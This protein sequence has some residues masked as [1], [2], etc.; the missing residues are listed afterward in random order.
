MFLEES[1]CWSKKWVSIGFA[2]FPACSNTFAKTSSRLNSS[3]SPYITHY[4]TTNTFMSIL[5]FLSA[6]E[7]PV[8][9]NIPHH[10]RY[11]NSYTL[12]S[13]EFFF[14]RSRSKHH[15]YKFS[16]ALYPTLYRLSCLI[17]DI[18]DTNI[19]LFPLPFSLSFLPFSL[20]FLRPFSLSFLHPFVCHVLDIVFVVISNFV[21]DSLQHARTRV[22][23][24]GRV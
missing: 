8:Y 21:H 22:C 1:G 18:L 4:T 12:H 10:I 2:I 20:S 19:F 13:W 16:L 11:I 5:S 6:H 17:T 23:G 9:I 14:V 24:C 3:G 7:P 15:H